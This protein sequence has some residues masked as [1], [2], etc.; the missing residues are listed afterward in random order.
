MTASGIKSNVAKIY[1]NVCQKWKKMYKKHLHG[2]SIVIILHVLSEQFVEVLNSY[3]LYYCS[4]C[5]VMIKVLKMR[6]RVD[7]KIILPYFHNFFINFK[8]KHNYSISPL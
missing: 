2:Q 3:Y 1:L 8:S 7:R 6:V 5:L 4:D